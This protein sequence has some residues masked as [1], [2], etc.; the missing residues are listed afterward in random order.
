MATKL[1]SS[2]ESGEITDGT[3]V[4]VDIA[5]GTISNDKLVSSSLTVTAGPGLTALWLAPRLFRFA[6]SHPEIELRLSASLK[7][8]DFDRDE[9]D[10]A[11]RYGAGRA[12]GMHVRPFATEW[13]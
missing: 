7:V 6:E 4:D 12:D 2:I 1:G 3:I 5:N 13:R 11:I 10:V 9:V 8:M